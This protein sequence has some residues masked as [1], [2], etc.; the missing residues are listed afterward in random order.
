LPDRRA[1]RICQLPAEF[2]FCE[3]HPCPAAA[4]VACRGIK[5]PTS[6]RS[7]ISLGSRESRTRG[8][9]TPASKPSRPSPSGATTGSAGAAPRIASRSRPLRPRSRRNRPAFLP[10]GSHSS[11]WD[12][13]MTSPG[14]PRTSWR[15]RYDDTEATRVSRLRGWSP[16]ALYPDRAGFCRPFRPQRLVSLR[17]RNASFA[18]S[19]SR[20]L[21]DTRGFL[22]LTTV[23][24]KKKVPIDAFVSERVLSFASADRAMPLDQELSPEAVLTPPRS[25][26][27]DHLIT[28]A[29]RRRR[30][31]I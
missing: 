5:W 3:S 11:G 20:H 24:R 27:H 4:R 22:N 31:R 16:L 2:F 15:R 14:T 18:E 30:A 25:P 26:H 9:G 29:A 8:R 19:E 12:F 28:T 10:E 13:S 23:R 6:P 17:E 1:W 21:E 7:G